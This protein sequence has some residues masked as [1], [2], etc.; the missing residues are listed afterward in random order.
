[1]IDGTLA[2]GVG[3]NTREDVI[4]VLK[5]IRESAVE[6]TTVPS[7]AGVVKLVW[8]SPGLSNWSTTVFVLSATTLVV[9]DPGGL[10]SL[11]TR[12]DANPD[13]VSV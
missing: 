11:S 12:P 1:M 8:I 6:G 3:G 10:P 2:P 13:S 7:Y 4:P 5:V 9:I